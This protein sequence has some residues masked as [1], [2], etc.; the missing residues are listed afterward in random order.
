MRLSFFFNHEM[1]SQDDWTIPYITNIKYPLF[2]QPSHHM[3]TLMT[4][5]PVE[6]AKLY[7]HFHFP[8]F[9]LVFPFFTPCQT[10]GAQDCNLTL[11][12]MY[13]CIDYREGELCLLWIPI[14]PSLW[15][16]VPPVSLYFSDTRFTA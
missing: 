15:I 3:R 8:L 11:D 1:A 4:T 14:N 5:L 6:V 16:P 7:P 12:T 10:G 9:W 2:G 13:L